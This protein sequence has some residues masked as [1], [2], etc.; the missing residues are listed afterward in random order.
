M[1]VYEQAE[2]LLRARLVTA[3]GKVRRNVEACVALGIW[4]LRQH[5]PAGEGRAFWVPRRELAGS[6][7]FQDQ[8]GLTS[9]QIRTARDALV[10]A[11]LLVLIEAGERGEGDA[12]HSPNV[13]ELGPE[14]A[15]F[16]PKTLSAQAEVAT[17]TPGK[18][19]IPLFVATC[20]RLPIG[21]PVIRKPPRPKDLHKALLEDHL[22]ELA[23]LPP[24][25]PTLSRAALSSNYLLR[26]WR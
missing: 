18:P 10:E 9:S 21:R 25:L 5:G 15:L 6:W 26:G 20:D 23:R 17:K 14:F 4:L 13:Y 22:R 2:A 24:P 19:G 7:R 8:V 3:T 1:N 16:F 12:K 11:G